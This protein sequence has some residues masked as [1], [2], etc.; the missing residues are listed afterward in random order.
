[1]SSSPRPTGTT[2]AAGAKKPPVVGAS[3]GEMSPAAAAAVGGFAGA[4][5]GVVAAGM[6][7]GDGGQDSARVEP[8]EPEQEMVAELDEKN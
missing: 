4:F 5:L 7:N 6:M 8:L 2:P 3:G 1:M